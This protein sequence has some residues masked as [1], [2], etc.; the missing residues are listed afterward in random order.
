VQHRGQLRLRSVVFDTIWPAQDELVAVCNRAWQRIRVPLL[1]R[2][3]RR[4]EIPHRRCSCGVHASNDVEVAASYLYLYDDVRQ[5][6][7]CG[8]AIGRVSLWGSVVEG[9]LGWRGSHAY[10]QRIFLPSTDRN[11]RDVDVDE[12][13]EG[14][15]RYRVPIEVVDDDAD[16]PVARAVRGVKQGRRRQRRA[17][18]SS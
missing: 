6:H 18:A 11:G 14:L 4:H 12:M 16:T 15:S 8:R 7:L 17:K 2:K 10:P 1:S 9:D 13:L 3:E 5:R